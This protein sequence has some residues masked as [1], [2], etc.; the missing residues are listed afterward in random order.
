VPVARGGDA[1]VENLRLLCRAHNQHAAERAFGADFMAEKR[2]ARG[3]RGRRHSSH[4]RDAATGEP[5]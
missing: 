1:T 3:Y 4:V 5:L 2:E